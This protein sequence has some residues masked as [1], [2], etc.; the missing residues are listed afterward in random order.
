ME[1]ISDGEL[2]NLRLSYDYAILSTVLRV[3][4]LNIAEG[5]RD[6]ES[7]WDDTMWP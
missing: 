1:I 7:A 2:A 6:G 3:L 4:G 5:A